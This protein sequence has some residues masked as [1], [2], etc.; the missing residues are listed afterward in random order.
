VS[1]GSLAASPPRNESRLVAA[2]SAAERQTLDKLLRK[3]LAQFQ[4]GMPT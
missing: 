4:E 2:L 1:G 3:L